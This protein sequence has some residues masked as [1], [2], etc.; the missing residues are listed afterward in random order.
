MPSPSTIAMHDEAVVTAEP[1]LD[2]PDDLDILVAAARKHA[3][4]L[5]AH[6]PTR[7][8]VLQ[9]AQRLDGLGA[10]QPPT[11]PLERDPA[12]VEIVP[13]PEIVDTGT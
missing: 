5:P 11:L 3:E 13:E 1:V 12:D 10:P 4:T 9:A 7:L 8:G 6:S 2:A